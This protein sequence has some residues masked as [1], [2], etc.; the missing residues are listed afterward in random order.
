VQLNSNL[1]EVMPHLN[2]HPTQ[3]GIPTAREA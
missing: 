3:A 1:I 2:Q